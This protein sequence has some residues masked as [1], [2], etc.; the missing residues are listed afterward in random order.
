[1]SSIA[2]IVAFDG[3]ASP[4][5]H[6]FLPIS[7]TRENGVVEAL[8]RENVSGVPVYAQC[9]VKIRLSKS[10]NGVYRA[11]TRVVVP[12]MESVS[13]QNS[14][15]YTAAPKVAY[16]NSEQKIAFFSER[17]DTVGRKLL[18]QL[19]LNVGGGVTTTVTPVTTGP[20]AE[21]YQLLVMPT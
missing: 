7:I 8:W 14:A 5:S 17:S 11:E 4:V 21:L 19:A 3:A 6:T 10:A 1:M 2:N 18:Q 16:E 9:W 13:G 15:G 20:V 12:V